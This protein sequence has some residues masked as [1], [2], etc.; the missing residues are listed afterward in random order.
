MTSQKEPCDFTKE[1]VLKPP[2]FSFHKQSLSNFYDARKKNGEW[3]VKNESRDF[4]KELFLK[5]PVFSFLKQSLS[6][7]YDARKKMVNDK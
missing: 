5:P 6:N 3:K 1:M 7:F 2:V 4:T